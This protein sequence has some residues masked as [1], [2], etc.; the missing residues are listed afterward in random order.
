MARDELTE[1]GLIFQEPEKPKAK[2]QV[3]QKHI[4]LAESEEEKEKE[5]KKVAKK[6]RHSTSAKTTA[7]ASKTAAE[8]SCSGSASNETL[9]GNNNYPLN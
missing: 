1:F 9:D 4:N 2:S 3:S 5:P 8:A 7:I 6:P